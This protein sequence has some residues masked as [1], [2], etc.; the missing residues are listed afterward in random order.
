VKE[1]PPS[2]TTWLLPIGVFIAMLAVWL[3]IASLR[4]FPPAS[5]PSPL[6]V[7]R[8]FGQEIASGQMLEDTIA[9][10]FRVTVGFVLAVVLAIPLGLWMGHHALARRALLPTVNFFRNLSP[11]AWIPFAVLW[12][13]IGDL[14]A[15]FLIFL[16]TFFTVALAVSA[17]VANIPVVYFQAAREYGLR[18]IQLLTGVTLPAIMPQVVTTL[19]VTAGV[20][21]MVVVAAEMIAGRDG[22]GF[23]IWDS[24][25]GLRT[26]LAVGEMI[27]I[28][29]IGVGIDRLLMQLTRMPSIRWGYER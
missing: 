3:L 10:L 23:A 6:A 24:R 21:W 14:P 2:R 9:S 8:G 22:L 16:S 29:I 18:G 20:A 11:L 4:L 13:G 19:R 26:D 5:F 17:A 7:A 12:F 15:I 28:G 25:N 1:E 27:V